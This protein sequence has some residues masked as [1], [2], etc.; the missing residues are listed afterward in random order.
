MALLRDDRGMTLIEVMIA[1]TILVVGILAL[2]NTVTTGYLDVA[3]SGG[4]STATAA[5]R[6]L[7]W[8]RENQTVNPRP[9]P[10]PV[11]KGGSFPPP[12]HPPPP[13]AHPALDLA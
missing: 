11:R 3:F 6:Q 4:E 7:L 10:P 2:M 5:P 13:A 1:I 8:P 9:P 12:T